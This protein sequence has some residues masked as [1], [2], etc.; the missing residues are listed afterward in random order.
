VLSRPRLD[1]QRASAVRHSEA[2]EIRGARSHLHRVLAALPRGVTCKVLPGSQLLM[3]LCVPVSQDYE[4]VVGLYPTLKPIVA[5]R[6]A[7]KGTRLFR[8]LFVVELASHL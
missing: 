8:E 3:C 1:V 4:R 6:I 2:T 7:E 5:E